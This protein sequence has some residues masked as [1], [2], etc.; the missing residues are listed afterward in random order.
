M[1]FF[2]FFFTVIWLTLKQMLWIYRIN[3]LV[4]V[5]FMFRNHPALLKTTSSLVW[6]WKRWTERTPT[7]FVLPQ[8]ERSEVRRSSSC[9]TAGEAPLTIGAPSTPETSSRSAGAPWRN[10]AYSRLETSVSAAV[11]VVVF[12]RCALSVMCHLDV[13]NSGRFEQFC[14]LRTID[15]RTWS[16][17]ILYCL[18]C[19][20][21]ARCINVLYII[22]SS[23]NSITFQ[24][25]IFIPTLTA[26]VCYTKT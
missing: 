10:T 25:S 2:I 16:W 15:D 7:W 21:S 8:W 9:L 23:Y 11:I 26:H 18:L 17:L 1:F 22:S 6:S 13:V 12:S 19:F 20:G 14:V 3:L 5:Y 24:N 4:Y